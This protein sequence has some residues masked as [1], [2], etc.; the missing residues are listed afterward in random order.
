MKQNKKKKFKEAETMKKNLLINDVAVTINRMYEFYGRKNVDVFEIYNFYINHTPFLHTDEIK[1]IVNDE[2]KIRE[3][4]LLNEYLLN[5][6]KYS[7]LYDDLDL[8]SKPHQYLKRF[9]YYLVKNI[10]ENHNLIYEVLKMVD[11]EK[12]LEKLIEK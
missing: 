6:N 3:I 11:N 4:N 1:T 12:Y 9:L 10:Y 7:N 5:N 2:E 8:K